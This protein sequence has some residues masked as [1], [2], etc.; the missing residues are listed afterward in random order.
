MLWSAAKW[1]FSITRLAVGVGAVMFCM[2]C[3]ANL[4]SLVARYNANRYLSPESFDVEY[5]TG[6]GRPGSRSGAGMNK[7]I[8]TA[9]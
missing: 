1:S 9:V 4:D 6:P 5:Y 8:R 7:P 2:L 3:L